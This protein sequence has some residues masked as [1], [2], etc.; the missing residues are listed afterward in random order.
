MKDFKIGD[1]YYLHYCGKDYPYVVQDILN[2]LILVNENQPPL[3][4]P[5][6]AI[7]VEDFDMYN[8]AYGFT[9]ADEAPQHDKTDDY[10]P[11]K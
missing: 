2:R 4:E 3:G 8:E 5:L 7:R 11:E 10:E 1:R 9:K 6:T